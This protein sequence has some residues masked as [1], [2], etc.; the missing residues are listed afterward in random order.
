MHEASRRRTCKDLEH[1]SAFLEP[2]L[3]CELQ[4][5]LVVLQVVELVAVDVVA[6][7]WH[8]IVVLFREVLIFFSVVS[9][10]FIL[11]VVFVLY[12]VAMVSEASGLKHRLSHLEAFVIFFAPCGVTQL[13]LLVD[14]LLLLLLEQL[15]FVEV[16]ELL[17][18][19]ALLLELQLSSLKPLLLRLQLFL[20]RL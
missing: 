12:K 14:E 15:L 19:E 1:P 2:L 11:G 3:F 5:V 9:I 13:L 10:D 18:L 20:L 8:D 4:V 16:E 7:G 17:L 6:V